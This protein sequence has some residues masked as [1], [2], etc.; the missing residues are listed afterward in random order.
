M[1][2]IFS[3][4]CFMIFIK[5]NVEHIS[6][7]YFTGIIFIASIFF[8]ITGLICGLQS[9]INPYAYKSRLLGMSGLVF[10]VLPWVYVLWVRI[11]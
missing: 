4:F 3:I 9:V 6:T 2:G 8:S 1:F 11:I 10:S 5:F 7:T